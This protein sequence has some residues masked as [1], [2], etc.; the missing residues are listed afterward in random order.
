[1]RRLQVQ[2]PQYLTVAGQ[3]HAQRPAVPTGHPNLSHPP[4]SLLSLLPE[5][6]LFLH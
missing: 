2:T 1:M 5:M 6:A 3:I 4:A